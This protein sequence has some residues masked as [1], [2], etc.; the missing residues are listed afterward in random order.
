M[1]QYPVNVGNCKFDDAEFVCKTLV[2]WKKKGSKGAMPDLSYFAGEIIFKAGDASEYAYFV[3]EGSVEIL[4][5]FPE[6]P[7]RLGIVSNG[8]IFGEMGLVDERPRS[9]TARAVAQTHLKAIT[10]DEFIELVINKPEEAFKYLGMFF[11]RLRAMN[12]RISDAIEEFVVEEGNVKLS[13]VRLRPSNN[14]LDLSLPPEGVE[15]E[16]FPFRIGR[17]TS[18]S[19]DPLEVNDLLLKDSHPY[20]VSR[21]HFAI[22]KASNA[23][24]VEDRGSYL[25]TIVNGT[26]I[27]GNHKGA[28]IALNNGKNE[29]IAGNEH[30]PFVFEI[31]LF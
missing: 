4:R 12:M 11:E 16:R 29:V 18:H 5:D 31:E 22:T 26:V 21:N 17:R 6:N 7:I 24:Y 30:S 25:G 1:K 3:V 15:I 20:N 10:R 13:G 2:E 9:L 8:E 14:Q 27:G 19:R 28:K 23:V